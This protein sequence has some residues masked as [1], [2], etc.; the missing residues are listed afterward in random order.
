MP[1]DSPSPTGAL[2]QRIADTSADKLGGSDSGLPSNSESMAPKSRSFFH[3]FSRRGADS[4]EIRDMRFINQLATL[5]S[6]KTF[7]LNEAVQIRPEDVALFS[8][9]R[10]YH[11]R[12]SDRG[13]LPTV[14]EWDLLDKHSQTLFGYLDEDLKRRFRLKQTANLIAGLP[15][16]LILLALLSLV[17]A[18]LTLDRK[19][20]LVSYFVWTMC[21]G[22]I[23]A[24]AFLSVNALSIQKDVTFDLANQSLLAVRIVL[25]ALFG[26]VLSIPIGFSAFVNFCESIALGDPNPG[27]ANSV[28]AFSLQAALLLLPFVL[29]FSTSLVIL[30]MNRLVESIAVFFGSR[31]GPDGRS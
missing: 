30:V 19:I 21:L 6:L 5:T 8:F 4:N 16:A 22:A 3:R 24:M 13:R 17:F 15:I 9:G 2:N 25:G 1:L 27:A 29:G 11:L 18:A 7:L 12:H 26:V 31:P 14:E 23:G 20:I 28:S 10:L